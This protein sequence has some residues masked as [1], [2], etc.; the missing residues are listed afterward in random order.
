MKKM[1]ICTAALAFA[2]TCAVA[3]ASFAGNAG[4]A[5][6]TL[7]DTGKK[8]AHFPHKAHQDREKCES[9]HH[10][11]NADGTQGPY[12]AG[13]EAKCKTCHNS[14]MANKA[15]GS[16]KQAA[17]A[18]CKGCHKEKGAPTKCNACHVK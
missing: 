18:R 11:K 7:S 9:C 4:P 5:E 2:F 17:H 14:E 1:I 10:T 12:V 6:I 15:L 8:P 16:L 13:K 3:G